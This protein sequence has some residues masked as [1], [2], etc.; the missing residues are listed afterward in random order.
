V[1]GRGHGEAVLDELTSVL[2]RFVIFAQP[3]APATIALWIAHTH[4]LDAADHSP[5]LAIVSP[6]K[7][8]GKTTLLDLITDLAYK[9]APIVHITPANL[10]RSIDDG[11]RT[12]VLD[13]ADT[14]EIGRQLVACLSSS[15]G[16]R[17]KGLTRR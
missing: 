4:V 7:R 2:Q 6:D 3:Y 9:A 8:C 15:L 1:A 14:Y 11:Y 16:H 17:T 5:I 10:F 12:L 13:E